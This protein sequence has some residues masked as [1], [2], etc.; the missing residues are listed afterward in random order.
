MTAPVAG[1]REKPA[2]QSHVSSSGA[3]GGSAVELAG[4]GAV[5]IVPLDQEDLDPPA[6]R[7]D[8]EQARGK[9]AR[10]V[11]HQKVA[12]GEVLGQI[13]ESGVRD[14]RRGSR[15]VPADDHETRGIALGRG[16]LRDPSRREL[17]VELVEPHVRAA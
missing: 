8:P 14:P 16:M 12:R 13:A 6:R 9:D 11:D 7:L 4:V 1:A 2:R 10:V 17:V 15:R 5:V 3:V